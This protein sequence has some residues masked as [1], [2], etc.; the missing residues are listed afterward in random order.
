MHDKVETAALTAVTVTVI[1]VIVAS[2]GF[3]LPVLAFAAKMLSRIV[4]NGLG[5]TLIV[6]GTGWVVHTRPD[7]RRK[8]RALVRI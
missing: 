7:L 4:L 3:I 2:T 6:G 8:V 1:V 5:L